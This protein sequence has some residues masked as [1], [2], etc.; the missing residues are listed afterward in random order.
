MVGVERFAGRLATLMELGPFLTDGLADQRLGPL[1]E[2]AGRWRA[3]P[4]AFVRKVIARL[5]GPYPFKAIGAR[6]SRRLA[7]P[8]HDVRMLQQVALL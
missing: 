5:Q 6:G 4:F 8:L 2:Q 3:R 1:V 7:K